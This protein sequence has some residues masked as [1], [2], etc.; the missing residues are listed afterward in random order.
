MD[1]VVGSN[2]YILGSK[3]SRREYAAD[4][5]KLPEDGLAVDLVF[6]EAPFNRPSV[7]FPD[8]KLNL[9]SILL[10]DDGVYQNVIS[11]NIDF[12]TALRC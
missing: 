5:L 3:K 10:I 9:F 2:G 1:N 12:I 4:A 7:K 6:Y 8:P 11:F